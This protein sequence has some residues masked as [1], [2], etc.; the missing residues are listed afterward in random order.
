MERMDEYVSAMLL[1]F[2][3]VENWHTSIGYFPVA[4]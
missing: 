1:L 2:D 3:D 4:A